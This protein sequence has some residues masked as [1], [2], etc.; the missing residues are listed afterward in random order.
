MA[1]DFLAYDKKK[2]KGG[3]KGESS[4]KGGLLGAR[5]GEVDQNAGQEETQDIKKEDAVT[6]KTEKKAAIKEALGGGTG[7]R[8]LQFLKGIK[9]DIKGDIRDIKEKPRS[10]SS[11]GLEIEKKVGMGGLLAGAIEKAEGRGD[12]LG[13]LDRA[14]KLE[15]EIEG[16]ILESG[17]RYRIVK[18]KDEKTPTYVVSMPELT[19]DD[20]KAIKALE[21]KAISEITVDPE[22]I[23]D[24]EKKKETFLKEVMNVIDKSKYDFPEPKKRA[25]AELI[26]QDMVGYGLLEPL[27][28]DDALEEIMVVGT[29]KSVYVYHRKHGMCK[30]NIFFE[31]D[32]ESENII[33]RIA[34][35]I[36]RRV[37]MS[38]P[39]LDARLPDGSRVN[40]TVRPVSLDGPSLT[41]RKFKEDPLTV[42]DI[43]KF[44]TMTAELASFLWLA[45]EGYGVKPANLLV[46]GG[47]GS[48]K[49]T[50]LN[51][52]G[53]FIPG[54]DRVITIEDTAE[55][56]L[57]IKHWIRLETRPPN[58]EGR[59]EV[60]MDMLLKNTLRMRPDRIIV[61]EVRGAEAGTLLASMN[62]GQN[63]CLGTLHANTAKE[64]VTRLTSAPMNVPVVM[65]PSLNLILMQNRFSYKGKTVRRITE[66]AE[67]GGLQKGMPQINIIYEW[68]P[69]DDKVKRTGVPS[70]IKRKLADL[71]GVS[72]DELENER[73]RREAILQY[74]V[75]KGFRGVKEVGKLI[76]EYYI[77]PEKVLAKIGGTPSPDISD[78]DEGEKS[79]SAPESGQH[80]PAAEPGERE[81]KDG[82]EGRGLLGRFLKDEKDESAGQEPAAK[83]VVEK[84]EFREIVYVESEKNPLYL[85]PLQKFSAKD[86]DLVEEI[87]RTA[88]NEINVDPTTIGDKKE[89]TEIFT[90]KV[91]QIIKG[92]FPY[93]P[94]S[95]RETYTKVVV[96]NMI[97]F[98]LLEF[99][100]IDD[101]LEELMVVGTNEPIY[102][103]HRKYGTCKT[104]LSF[105]TDEE[106]IRIIEKIASSIGR[107][108]DKSTPLLD[109]RLP[110]GSRVNATIPPISV[111]GPTITI[112]KFKKDPLTI[113]DLINFRTLNI[114]VSTYLWIIAEGLGIKP[115][116][117]LTAGGS[118]CGKT[119]TLN[120]LCS[121]IPS[122]DRVITIEDTAELHIP[123]EHTVRLETRPPNVEGE[124]EVTMDDLVKNTLR[125]RP[126][127][128]IVGEVRGAEARTLFTAMNT[129]HDG[130]MGT[131]HANSAKETITRLTNPPMEVPKIMLPALDLILMQNK[132]MYNGDTVRRITEI[133]EIAPQDEDKLALNTVYEWDP[134]TDSLKPTGVP[135][136]LKQKIAKLKGWT[137]D[138][139]NKEI[140]RRETVLKWM[141]DNNIRD[142]ND[143]AAN[144]GR[145]YSDPEGLLAMINDKKSKSDHEETG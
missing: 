16:D 132:I 38:S 89:A 137:I 10:K 102:V 56:Q 2:K 111:K 18:R 35:S 19:S 145:Y 97:G 135:S 53:S 104:N 15:K 140:S 131:V 7:E 50:T 94:V 74:M 130:C 21:T 119:T 8:K 93:I 133:A 110:D 73:K 62:T 118:G 76:N 70:A 91:M 12:F 134:K 13:T 44:G 27:L 86:R 85:V 1:Y 84:N 92:Y 66:I 82:G 30:T 143:V 117:I 144:F 26:V 80:E 36:G 105:D 141:V 58:V 90:K 139:L 39:L 6:Q 64:T 43:I 59:G 99:L 123:I 23:H 103:N 121:F 40:A 33:A 142:I 4:I 28:Q 138:E 22:S 34:R 108:V 122:T 79:E 68:D 107:R 25:F 120:C 75:D 41:I 48:G 77:S 136:L 65:I 78:M 49:T 71:K 45:T 57:P 24:R 11:L 116:N 114:E 29:K 69:K 115:G 109:A 126:D 96:Q 98:G 55:L 32:E 42:I 14:G 51:C 112:R 100:L 63:G 88:I 47:T 52:L 60:S 124:G 87:E 72:M 67:V 128:V 95:K 129:G 83:E 106:S 20:R 127:R 37:D 17:D 113:M 9:E 81:E 5:I 61:G 125:M 31:E 3:F 101:D 46:S 54:T